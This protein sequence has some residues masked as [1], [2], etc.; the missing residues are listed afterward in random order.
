MV[1]QPLDRHLETLD[2]EPMTHMRYEGII[3]ST[4]AE[5][6]PLGGG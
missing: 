5:N 1:N 2:L 6:G 3:L 4:T